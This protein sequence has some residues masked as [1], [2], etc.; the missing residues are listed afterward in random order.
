MPPHFGNT[1]NSF[2]ITIVPPSKGDPRMDADL[3]E[4]DQLEAL[5]DEDGF[6]T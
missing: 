4:A 5:L 1:I 2:S 6:K 3:N